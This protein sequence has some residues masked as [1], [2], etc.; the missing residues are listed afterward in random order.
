MKTPLR[1]L[2]VDDEPLARAGIRLLAEPLSDL[3]IV[4]EAE[5][6]HSAKRALAQLSPDLLLLDIQMPGGTGFDLL[7][8]LPHEQLPLVVFVTAYDIHAVRAFS[9][10]AIDYLLKPVSAERFG[11][12]ITRVQELASNRSLAPY[13]ESIERLISQV[14]TDGLERLAATWPDRLL[15]REVG[16]SF[17]V[18]VATIRWIEAEDYYVRL[19]CLNQSPLLRESLQSLEQRLDPARFIR[20][21]RSSMVAIMAIRSISFESD[22]PHLLL[23]DGTRLPIGRTYKEHLKLLLARS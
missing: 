10:Q 7:A 16:R 4:G 1:T 9:L 2:I 19:H 15:V 23:T 21:H 11:Q 22:E 12:T 8:G 17:F 18:P 20:I 14:G 3:Q 5:D 6:L 13:R